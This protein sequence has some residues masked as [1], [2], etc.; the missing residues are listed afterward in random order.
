MKRVFK[1]ELSNTWNEIH[2]IDEETNE[3]T[4]YMQDK[5]FGFTFSHSTQ[6]VIEMGYTSTINCIKKLSERKILGTE[7]NYEEQMESERIGHINLLAEQKRIKSNPE[8]YRSRLAMLK[9]A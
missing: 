7:V 6:S 5:Q 4:Q 9:L 2:V 8:E 1:R 3:F